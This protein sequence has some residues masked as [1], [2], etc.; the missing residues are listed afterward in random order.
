MTLEAHSSSAVSLAQLDS[1]MNTK[2]LGRAVGYNN[3]L[4]DSIDSTNTRAAELAGQGAPEGVLVIARQQTAGRG[5]LGRAWLSPMDSGVYLSIILRP[6]APISSLP[7]LTIAAGV[8]AAA[9]ISNAS[10]V[11]VGL[12]WVNDLVYDGRKVGGILCE[13]PRSPGI[14]ENSTQS[15][16]PMIVGIGINVSLNDEDVPD[17]LRSKV[18]W[19]ERISGNAI[20]RSK[21]VAEIV[22]EFETVYK[23]MLSG[24]AAGVVERWRHQSVTLGKQIVATSGSRSFEGVAVDIAEDGSLI[25][26]TVSEGRKNLHA[27]EITIRQK[28]GSYC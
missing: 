13:L 9:G 4:W 14:V 15:A 1:Y 16:Q 27:G 18:E 7:L 6:A 28:D 20:D 22:N 24:E 5:R 25:V 19:L 12:K 11:T 21:L 2:V 17:E 8:S 10:N 3:E 23:Q 26:D